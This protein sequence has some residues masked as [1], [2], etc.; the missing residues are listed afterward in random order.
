[1]WRWHYSTVVITAPP[2][3]LSSN[4]RCMM[5]PAGQQATNYQPSPQF[6]GSQPTSLRT[7]PDSLRTSRARSPARSGLSGSALSCRAL[8]A[9]TRPT[10]V[11]YCSGCCSCRGN[12]CFKS[13]LEI[14][15]TYA[16]HWFHQI[17]TQVRACRSLASGMTWVCISKSLSWSC[18]DFQKK[19]FNLLK[20]HTVV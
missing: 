16:H 18:P 3:F 11:S 7:G 13:H 20:Q 1:M 8:P 5:L 9:A 14:F 10:E 4:L 19:L 15:H 2:F 12:Y 17:K 6:W